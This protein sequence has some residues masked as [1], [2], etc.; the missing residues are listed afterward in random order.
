M[1]YIKLTV[2]FALLM[3][4]GSA[5]VFAQQMESRYSRVDEVMDWGAATTRLVVD[6]G[7]EVS[8]GAVSTDSFDVHVSRSDPRLAEPFL[9]EGL[10]KVT[11]AYV[12]DASGNPVMSGRYA[13][14]VMEVGP[15]TSLGNALNYARD[16][17]VG[18]NFNAWTENAYTITQKKPI[19]DI[20]GGLVA[21]RM[22]GYTRVGI[23][24]FEFGTSSYTD[25]EH[26]L[27][28]LPFAH[29]SPP[30]DDRKNP[31]IIWLHGGGEGGNDPSIPIAANRA[32]AFVSA[33]LQAT[34]GGAYV[35]APQSP[36]R[37]M[38]GPTGQQGG[39]EKQDALSI[40][41]RATQDLVE[42][43][44]A[45]Q[46]DVDTDRI[47]IAGASNG[48][49]LTVR[50]V[51]DR[52]DYY[53]AAL[54][55][56]EPLNLD[57]VSDEELTG[58]LDLPMWLVTAATDSVVDPD[59]FPVPLYARL[60][61]LGAEQIHLSFLPNVVDMTG[62]YFSEDGTPHEYNGHWSWIPTYNNHLAYVDGGGGQLY[63]PIA[64]AVDDIAGRK[65]V[66]VMDWLAAQ[67][68]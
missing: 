7:A 10:R 32:T 1:K 36:T 43:F 28:E 8:K 50:L 47:Y 12:A 17:V 44:V 60:R 29:Y 62:N 22:D 51:L 61:K 11:D 56:A 27:I 59:R 9:E 66:T 34:F 46:P 45:E 26:G 30:A 21:T 37:W 54:A 42:S 39:S 23:D 19:G 5:P 20:Q 57:Y 40:Y 35:L 13:A 53:A 6:L 24:E 48:G 41:T 52:P 68:K 67:S 33:E 49:W 58:I 18:N 65:V 3:A 25:A 63:G 14:L 55:V 4:T 16:P 15:T 64:Q 31:L 2:V 38:H